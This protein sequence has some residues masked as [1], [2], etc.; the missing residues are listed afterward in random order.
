[1]VREIKGRPVKEWKVP[2]ETAIPEGRYR[3][4]L[5]YSPRFGSDTITLN[6]VTGF[7][8]IRMHGGNTV[9]DTDGCPLLG[10]KL[11]ANGI[12]PGTSQPAVKLVKAIIKEA[13]KA[14]QQVWID[15]R[16]A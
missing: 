8:Y 4:T 5:E 12:A 11:D 7:D 16:N 10:M 6:N 3:I 13:I 9:K 2:G 1:M 15:V 14:G